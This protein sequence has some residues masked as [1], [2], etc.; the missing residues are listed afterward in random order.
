M[1]VAP[2]GSATVVEQYTYSPYGQVVYAGIL[3]AEAP[4][5]RVGFQGL[6][7]DRFDSP[8]AGHTLAPATGQPGGASSAI[9]GLYYARNRFYSPT[10]GRFVTRDVKAAGLPICEHM[11][12][13]GRSLV[14]TKGSFE[15]K[16]HFP[17]GQNSY[18]FVRNLPTGRRD[19][20]GLF[21]T[22]GD[23]TDAVGIAS[24]AYSAYDTGS[25][26]L[27]MVRAFVNGVS[28]SNIMFGVAI[29]LASNHLGGKAF[30][31]ALDLA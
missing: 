1:R 10:L 30:D 5:S 2:D 17:D 11:A 27:S 7:F 21:F 18:G 9:T 13:F 25:S 8:R 14:F 19:P 16:S 24:R 3:D 6:F 23:I 15:P 29:E 4:L 20:S 22:Y 28:I 26:L 12:F 31:K